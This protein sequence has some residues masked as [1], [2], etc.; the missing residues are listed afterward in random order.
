MD[1]GTL[2]LTILGMWAVTFAVKVG[3]IALLARR[4]LP[5]SVIGTIRP[6]RSQ[7]W[8]PCSRPMC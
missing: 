3:P 2:L 6:R 5:P 1:Q 8:L 7:S 4:R